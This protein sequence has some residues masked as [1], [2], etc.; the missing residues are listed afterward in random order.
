MDYSQTSEEV[1]N[2]GKIL[3]ILSETMPIIIII[4]II[5]NSLAFTI[6]MRKKFRKFSFSFYYKIL[7]ITNTIMLIFSFHYWALPVFKINIIGINEIFCKFNNYIFFVAESI[8]AYTL[9]LIALDRMV[10][11]VFPQRFNSFKKKNVQVLLVFIVC[12]CCLL[13]HILQPIRLSRNVYTNVCQYKSMTERRIIGIIAFATEL[14]AIFIINNILTIAT[15]FYILRSRAKFKVM[16]LN[17]IKNKRALRDRKFAINSIM[18]NVVSLFLKLPFLFFCT[19]M[20][21]TILNNIKPYIL[22]KIIHSSIILN[23]IDNSSSLFVNI[24]VNSIFRNE[25][26]IMFKLKKLETRIR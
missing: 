16:N 2:T 17:N 21:D 3:K 4:G 5:S 10:T 11:I 22:L 19:V 26:L 25:F 24:F 8:S 7:T 23:L 12:T 14:T 1:Y 20:P 9:S 18:L 6:F 13:L 15:I